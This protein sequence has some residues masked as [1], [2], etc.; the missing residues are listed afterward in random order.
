M[1]S[2]TKCRTVRRARSSRASSC[3]R[4]SSIRTIRRS[5]R[6]WNIKGLWTAGDIGYLDDDGFLYLSDR[7]NDMVISG[8]V[9][10]YPKEIETELYELPGVFDCAVFGIPDEEFGEA[11]AAIIQR[12]AGRIARRSAG[13]RVPARTH[14]QVQTAEGHRVPRRAAARRLGQIVQAQI[15]RRIL[16][17]RRPPDLIIY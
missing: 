10:I 3:I 5:A 2:A 13:A 7:K 11:L 12:V 14:R 1:H 9:N 4:T 17:G 16:E 8:G 6:R 15:A